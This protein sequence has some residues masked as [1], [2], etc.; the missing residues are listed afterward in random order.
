MKKKG[1]EA[2]ELIERELRWRTRGVISNATALTTAGVVLNAAIFPASAPK[3]LSERSRELVGP[4]IIK[5]SVLES[6]Q[7]VDVSPTFK[8]KIW[9]RIESA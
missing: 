7:R 9:S 3:V 1:I 5:I 6:S 2:R 4:T 8:Y